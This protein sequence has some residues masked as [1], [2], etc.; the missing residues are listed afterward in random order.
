[1]SS[2][3]GHIWEVLRKVEAKLLGRHKGL[4]FNGRAGE[5]PG[6]GRQPQSGEAAE[7]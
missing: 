6:L 3:T 2:Y 7:R 5:P 4:G 1:M